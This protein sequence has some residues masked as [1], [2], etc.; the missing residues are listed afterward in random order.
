MPLNAA[1][2]STCSSGDGRRVV[3]LLAN[4]FTHDARADKQ[5]RSLMSRDFQVSM[6]AVRRE[7]L[8]DR[9]TIDGVDVHRIPMDLRGLWRAT[10]CAA[11]WWCKPLMRLILRP[12][13]LPGEVARSGVSRRL[14]PKVA[15][16]FAFNASLARGA[17]ALKPDA[18][19][20]HDLETLLAATMVK[21]IAGVPVIYD[22]HELYLE[23]NI[24][25][26]ARWRGRMFWGLIEWFCSACGVDAFITVNQSIADHLNQRYPRL[27]PGVIVK[28]ATPPQHEPIEYDGRLHAAA[29][30]DGRFKIL[31]YQGG[32]APNRGLEA[33]VRAGTLLPPEWRV[34]LMGWGAL[35]D[36][37]RSLARRLD[38]AGDRIS[39]VA[40]APFRELPRWT[41]GASVGVIPYENICLNHWLC[42]PNKLWEYPASGVPVLASPFPELKRVIEGFGIGRLL[43]D[44]IT[45]ENI[46]E[47]V[48]V[49]T[50]PEL[51][52]MRANCRRFIE[53][54]N[55]T[56]YQERLIETYET[57]LARRTSAKPEPE[58]GRRGASPQAAGA[59]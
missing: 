15:R 33:L 31:L 17:L 42:S 58:K 30:L 5:A 13:L 35:E 10:A 36:Q 45:A 29:K 48:G 16:F 54:D 4:D 12:A 47:V 21:R 37:L 51:A 49:L 56:V 34:V 57:V 2:I 59:R 1:S 19:H 52:L 27:P 41:A 38:F 50:E 9:Q 39:F 8:P 32:F 14:L 26:G 44:P 22:S 18:V 53:Q 3:M 7:G 43:S 40:A 28:N 11:L 46:A 20:A 55:W 24:G 25:K 23:R 6:I